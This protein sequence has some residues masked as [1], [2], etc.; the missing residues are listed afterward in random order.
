MLITLMVIGGGG[1]GRGN[2]GPRG[3]GGGG[4]RTNVPGVQD[5]GGNPLTGRGSSINFTWFIYCHCR[6]WRWWIKSSSSRKSWCRFCIR[7]YYLQMVV[8]EED[9][10]HWYTQMEAS[11]GGSGGGE[12]IHLELTQVDLE[13][14]HQL[15]HHKE[16][17]E[18]MV[19]PLVHH[20]LVV[21][22]SG[23]AGGNSQVVQLVVLVDYR[24]QSAG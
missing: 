21:V 4:L 8:V 24:L 10:R 2:G 22:V 15:L 11:G 16:I 9:M 19:H 7:F 23:G 12:T 20:L 17:Q 13:T 5:S 1:G 14:I 18:V 3:G 6:W